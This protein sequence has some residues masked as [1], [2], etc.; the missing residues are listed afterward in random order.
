MLCQDVPREGIVVNALRL[1]LYY[2]PPGEQ[3]GRS[4]IGIGLQGL[5]TPEIDKRVGAEFPNPA[6]GRQRRASARSLERGVALPAVVPAVLVTRW[7]SLA[8]RLAYGNGGISFIGAN[9]PDSVGLRVSSG[10]IR[11]NAQ[12]IKALLAQVQRNA[13]SG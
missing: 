10:C 7:G 12:N 8:L 13:G 9:A 5:E 4:I 2:F 6:P 11:M 3:A 1:H